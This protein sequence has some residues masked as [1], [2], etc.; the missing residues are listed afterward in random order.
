M[1]ASSHQLHYDEHHVC[2]ATAKQLCQVGEAACVTTLSHNGDV[3]AHT[4]HCPKTL[5]TVYYMEHLLQIRELEMLVV[6]KW[7]YHL[8][9]EFPCRQSRNPS[10]DWQWRRLFAQGTAW[11]ADVVAVDP[12]DDHKY[13]RNVPES[14]TW[15]EACFEAGGCIPDIQILGQTAF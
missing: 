4:I 10:V 12:V 5:S 2:T 8:V 13:A 7:A 1:G 3:M 9:S 11:G 15:E 6:P 14:I